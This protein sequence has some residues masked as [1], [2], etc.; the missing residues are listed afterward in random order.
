MSV[1]MF[2]VYFKQPSL[3]LLQY[4]KC[5]SWSLPIHIKYSGFETGVLMVDLVNIIAADALALCIAYF[6]K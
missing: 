3:S 5:C 2:V 1:A 4:A 6:V